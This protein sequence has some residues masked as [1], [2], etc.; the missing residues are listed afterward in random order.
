MSPHIDTNNHFFLWKKSVLGGDGQQTGIQT[1][2]FNTCPCDLHV[3]MFIIWYTYIYIYINVYVC[4]CEYIYVA[5]YIMYMW[6]Y[7]RTNISCIYIYICVSIQSRSPHP[8][9]HC[10]RPW[11]HCQKL[12]IFVWES[13]GICGAWACLPATRFFPLPLPSIR[14]LGEKIEFAFWAGT[15][16]VT[17]KE[18]S[19]PVL[20]RRVTTRRGR[21]RELPDLNGSR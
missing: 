18:G 2:T 13:R 20:P 3:Y 6:I 10:Q 17:L 14:L 4:I 8:L 11:W 1:Y 5:I 9:V 15:K 21:K 19:W 16:I 12:E 7:I